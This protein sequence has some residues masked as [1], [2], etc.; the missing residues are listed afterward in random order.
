MCLGHRNGRIFVMTVKIPESAVTSMA[1]IEALEDMGLLESTEQQRHEAES[2]GP[3][4]A[5]EMQLDQEKL[6]KP[7]GELWE[8][9][10]TFPTK[11]VV[12]EGLTS[13]NG[14]PIE[15]TMSEKDGIFFVGLYENSGDDDNV[16]AIG[17]STFKQIPKNP[18]H[19]AYMTMDTAD[20]GLFKY[21]EELHNDPNLRHIYEIINNDAYTILRE[22]QHQG[23]GTALLDISMATAAEMGYD[24]MRFDANSEAGMGLIEHS[25]YAVE[26]VQDEYGFASLNVYIGP[27]A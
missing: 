22:H 23:L 19:E 10:E 13:G 21:Q 1:D 25:G 2:H 27:P 26:P 16:T 6:W 8:N 12:I 20:V 7:F 18:W 24:F 15:A 3:R 4:S 11:R 17:Y 14:Y 5:A 9:R